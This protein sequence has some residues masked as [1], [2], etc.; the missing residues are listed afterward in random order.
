MSHRLLLLLPHSSKPEYHFESRDDFSPLLVHP[1]LKIPCLLCC[2]SPRR[3]IICLFTFDTFQLQSYITPLTPA[4]M[5]TGVSVFFCLSFAPR[6]PIITVEL[7]KWLSRDETRQL[8]LGPGRTVD[9]QGNALPLLNVRLL[10]ESR[11]L[12]FFF[13]FLCLPA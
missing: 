9:A 5:A 2:V 1:T 6:G 8:S 7:L 3:L 10:F 12:V 4:T 13:R 11:A